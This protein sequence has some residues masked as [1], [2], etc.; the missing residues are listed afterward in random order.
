MMGDASRWS[1]LGIV[2]NNIKAGFT[3]VA[4][5]YSAARSGIIGLINN[6]RL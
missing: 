6:T 2:W 3:F 4:N 5:G 1:F